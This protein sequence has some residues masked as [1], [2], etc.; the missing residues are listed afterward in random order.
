MTTLQWQQVHA[1]RLAQHGLAPRFSSQNFMHAVNR[2]AG[3][4]AQV[5]SAAELAMCARVEGFSPQEVQTALFQKH[6]LVRTWAMR[7]TLHILAADELPLYV[8]A[9]EW[10][11]TAN[12]PAYFAE[13]GLSTTQQEAFLL[14]V[15]HVLEQGPLTREQLADALVQ[16][17][18]ISHI[19]EL[20]LSSSWG[21]PLKPS[22]FRGELCF[23]PGQGKNVTFMNPR[24]WIE[25]WPIIQPEV[26]QKEIARRYLR[27]YGPA[28]SDDFAF[29]WGSTKTFAKKL[30][31][32]IIDELEEV[33]VEGWHAF[34]LRESLPQLQSAT[35]VEQIHLLPLFDAY[36]IG[37]PR[38]CEPLLAPAYKRQV[39]NLQGWTFAVILVNGSI[40]GLWRSTIQRSQVIINVNL[41]CAS[42]ATIRDGIEIEAERLS[43]LFNKPV[44]LDYE[45]PTS[46]SLEAIN[47]T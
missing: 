5:L 24:T 12:W 23:G 27:A 19:R 14:A 22:A 7:S 17:T 46:S 35:A 2:T 3:I 26:A 8:A 6:T 21:S 31:Q 39:F 41:F 44:V 1:W 42:T 20:V 33:E 36:T 34:A 45:S 38:D 29:W 40:Q 9:R 32:S 37:M 18:G 25:Q 16:H 15:P 4:Q 10:Q 47:A 13:F 43:L 11:H 30:F 28:N